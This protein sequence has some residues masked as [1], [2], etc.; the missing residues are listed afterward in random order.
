MGQDIKAR[1][2]IG[3]RE[4]APTGPMYTE[5]G[6]SNIRLAIL[7]PEVQG[8]IPD[9]LPLYI[10][11]LLNN[12][13]K[14]FSAI[15]LID[16]QNLNRIISEQNIAASGRFSDK[17]FVS[18]GNLTNTQYFLFGTIQKLSGNRYSLQLSVTEAS[19]GVRKANFMKDGAPAQF[20]GNGT[21][22]N[23]ATAELL[24]QLGIHLTTAGKQAL[25]AGNTS[26]VLAEAGLARGI[27]AQ[28]GGSEVNALFNFAQAIT[29]D[30]SQ[31]EALSR[32]NTLSSSISGGTISQRIVND[33]QSRDQWIQAFKETARF[34]NNHPPFEIIFDPNLIQIGETDFA[35]RTAT[36]GM[37]IKLNASEAGFSALN[38]LLEGLERT[39]RR[40]AWG[41]SGWPFID[42]SPKTSGTV[43]FGG[44]RSFSFK[45]EI[46]LI[47]EKNKSLGKNSVI[48]NTEAIK[49]SAGDTKIQLPNI[50]E[51]IVS[52]SNI[53]AEDLT[54][55]LTIV[56]VAVNGIPSRVL[57]TSGYMKI[58]TG[59]LEKRNI[60][61]QLGHS[62]MVSSVAFS[63]DGR[64]VIS[65]STDRMI[66]FWNIIIGK[67]IAQFVS[68][69]DGEWVV[70][71]P[72]GYYKASSNGDKYLNVSVDNN[73]YGID[74]YREIY[75]KP[76]I[77][78]ARLQGESAP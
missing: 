32:L 2:G 5:N 74:Q 7:A 58:D 38:A 9:Y 64:Q 18:I 14:K 23:E 69:T 57:N 50:V 52:F 26:M 34:F 53:K 4:A 66:C 63:P 12:N 36:L 35:K 55:V 48:L 39:G 20:E 75:H 65:G 41:F 47:N 68:F 22:L 11:G 61:P 19:T 51:G 3:R 16:R 29:F 44:K 60:F 21:I 28:A 45:V 30:P 6:G 59:D 70:I 10:Q 49:L 27:T 24:E 56:I 37:R 67:E 46:S 77:I 42:V 78:E 1:G 25:L 76:Q 72:D 73:V 13:I 17:D 71:T 62:D 31:F 43:V 54:P 40:D 33:I 15:N 8:D